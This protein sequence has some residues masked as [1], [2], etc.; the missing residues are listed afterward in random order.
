[1]SNILDLNRRVLTLSLHACVM[2]IKQTFQCERFFFIE[3]LHKRRHGNPAL[4]L[5]LHF[6]EL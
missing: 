4:A 2:N 3:H 1:M 6:K 5:C